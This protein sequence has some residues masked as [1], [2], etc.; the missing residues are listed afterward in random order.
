MERKIII[1]EKIKRILINY[2]D[3]SP[4]K[5]VCG[6]LLGKKSDSVWECDE[7]IPLT[8][9]SDSQEVHYIPEPNEMFKA[10]NK[11][12]HM[13][14]QADKDLVGVFHTHPHHRAQPSITDLTGAGYQ[15]FYFIYSPKYNELNAFYYDGGDPKF[16]DA[17][18]DTE[19]KE[20]YHA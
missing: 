16:E 18:Y 10:L 3:Q 5:E 2:G 9:I 14:S 15:G 19:M 17:S 1:Q 6:F 7:F 13:D 4:T 11:T 20:Y 12:T 8:N